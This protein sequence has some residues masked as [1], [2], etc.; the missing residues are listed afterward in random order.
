M[1]IFKGLILIMLFGISSY[2]GFSFSKKYKSRVEELKE[3][4]GY[5]NIF[6]S[7]IKMT[8]ESIPQ[9]FKE[10]GKEGKTNIENIFLK[11]SNNMENMPAGE[12]W[13]KT[14]E[15]EK[16]NLNKEDI[17]VLKGLSNLL[18]KT[19]LEGQVSQIELVDN[20]LNTQIEKAEEEYKKNAKISK[21]LGS[22]VGLALVI[23]LI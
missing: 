9:I 21:T 12:A 2:I 22:I 16:T 19:D 6:L 7:K 1:F 11:S 10:I 15:S 5:L 3:I 18:G 14:I 20:F 23:I 17:E 4:K 8:Y 13:N